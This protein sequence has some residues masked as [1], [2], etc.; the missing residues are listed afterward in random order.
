MTKLKSSQ[1]SAEDSLA[2]VR[3]PFFKTIVGTGKYPSEETK[4]AIEPRVELVTHL[5]D[6]TK[7]KIRKHLIQ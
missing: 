4:K 6:S 5:R 1:Q 3:K 7:M 2:I